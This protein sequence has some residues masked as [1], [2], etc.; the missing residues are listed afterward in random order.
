M[1]SAITICSN[2]LLQ[3][4]DSPIASFA[5]SE[6]KRATTCANLW[7][8]VRDMMLRR[9][10]WP[11]ARK[12]VIL[13]PEATGTYTDLFDWGYSFLLPGD[14]MRSLQYGERGERLD[15]E[16]EGRRILA[17]TNVLPLVYVWRNED[18][19]LWDDALIDA[20]CLEMTARLAYP[21]TKSTSLAQLKRQE[22]DKFL[23]EAKS[24]AGQDNEPEDWGD[25][26]FTDV[27]G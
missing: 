17:N 21:I 5:A 16:I 26:P 9:H 4:G 19:A 18:P 8:Q 27:R 6:G 14:W 10:A 7:P 25:N 1:S 12:R 20:V 24:I 2:A 13:A 23:R 11:C 15:F 3:L 22:A